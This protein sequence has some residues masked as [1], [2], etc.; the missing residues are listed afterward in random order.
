MFRQIYLL[1]IAR[2]LNALRGIY[3]NWMTNWLPFLHIRREKS[4]ISYKN[5]VHVIPFYFSKVK[6]FFWYLVRVKVIS[7]S[8][9][10][11]FILLASSHFVASFCLDFT[12]GWQK[13]WTIHGTYIIDGNSENVTHTYERYFLRKKSDL[14]L[15]STVTTEIDTCARIS[16]SPSLV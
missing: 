9:N 14:G 13:A 10:N 5:T 16:E 1:F 7:Y 6:I 8:W 4:L 11:T 12:L 15:L 2:L 3:T